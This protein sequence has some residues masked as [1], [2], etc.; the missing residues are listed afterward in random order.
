MLA[1]GGQGVDAHHP[2]NSVCVAMRHVHCAAAEADLEPHCRPPELLSRCTSGREGD[3]G[4]AASL[5]GPR[6][7]VL[8][9]QAVDAVLQGSR[10]LASLCAASVQV[11]RWRQ[12]SGAGHLA[13]LVHSS[14]RRAPCSRYTVGCQAVE[15]VLQGSWPACALLLF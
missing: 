5:G 13:Q 8:S 9:C 4:K 14:Q 1:L 6:V 2:P 15:A 11:G 12:K 3:G 10:G 7:P